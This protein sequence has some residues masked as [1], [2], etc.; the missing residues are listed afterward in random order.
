MAEKF[1][2]TI[3]KESHISAL[4]VMKKDGA[5]SSRLLPLTTVKGYVNVAQ[6]AKI[7]AKKNAAELGLTIGETVAVDEVTYTEELREMDMETFLAH[8]TVVLAK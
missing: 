6:A 1:T 2:R 3:V 8:S 7:I 5:V 4:A